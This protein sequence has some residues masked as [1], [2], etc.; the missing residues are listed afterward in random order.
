MKIV[1]IVAVL[2][3]IALV[4]VFIFSSGPLANEMACSEG[5]TPANDTQGG[6]ACFTEDSDLPGGYTWDPR[7]NYKMN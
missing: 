3:V 1:M 6:S 4:G 2:A 7:G 5:E